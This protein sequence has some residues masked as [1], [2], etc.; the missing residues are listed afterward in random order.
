MLLLQNQNDEYL[1]F[2]RAQ[3]PHKGTFDLPGGFVADG[4][5]FL[6]GA[7]REL[8]EEANIEVGELTYYG[9]YPDSYFYKGVTYSTLCVAFKGYIRGD[10]IPE[11]NDELIEYKFF[12]LADIPVAEISFSAVRQAFMDLGF[13]K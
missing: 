10:Q 13:V 7:Q 8:R 4:E 1:L 2:R 9:S 6:D 11:P 12:K 3:E 5:T